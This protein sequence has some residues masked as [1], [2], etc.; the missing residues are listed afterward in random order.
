MILL[1][2]EFIAHIFAAHAHNNLNNSPNLSEIYSRCEQNIQQMVMSNTN[3]VFTKKPFEKQLRKYFKTCDKTIQS[4]IKITDLN[5]TSFNEV[6]LE[7]DPEPISVFNAHRELQSTRQLCETFMCFLFECKE[8]LLHIS[9]ILH[10]DDISYNKMP[11]QLEISQ[12][13]VELISKKS[14]VEAVH[15]EIYEKEKMFGEYYTKIKKQ[16]YALKNKKKR[17]KK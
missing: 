4:C 13:L 14:E 17:N 5:I 2:I 1:V 16:K 12:K 11:I 10:N 8:V 15:K 7:S 9:N 3:N 6:I